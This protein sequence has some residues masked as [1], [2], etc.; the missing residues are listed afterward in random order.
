M[1]EDIKTR[2]K[3]IGA[4]SPIERQV[5][6][7]KAA[8]EGYALINGKVTTLPEYMRP[9]MSGVTIEGLHP[10]VGVLD[11]ETL[12]TDRAAVITNIG[13]VIGNVLSGEI[14]ERFYVR[15]D[16]DQP[17][18]VKD[19]STIEFWEKM[20]DKKPEAYEEAM[21]PD[22][23]FSLEVALRQLNDFITKSELGKFGAKERYLFGNGPEFDNAIIDHAMGQ[24]GIR[25]SWYFR[26]NQSI[27]T[28]HWIEQLITRRH[29]ASA[30]TYDNLEHHALKDAEREFFGLHLEVSALKDYT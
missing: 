1:S 22:D 30:W 21:S 16:P 26:A 25:P 7:I 3:N 4:L 18:R 5:L 13:L 23:R 9:A 19:E 24:Y 2:L 20:K 6:R 15:V 11:I 10:I 29:S 8:S 28:G 12:S 17:D 14:L 27:R